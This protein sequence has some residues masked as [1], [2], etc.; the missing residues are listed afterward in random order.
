MAKK[1]KLKPRRL[2]GKPLGRPPY[3]VEARRIIS[4]RC[5][6]KLLDKIDARAG[7]T[8]LQRSDIIKH[9]LQLGLNSKDETSDVFA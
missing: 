3:A 5:P 8:G 2:S 6:V 9:L 7:K 1:R 4:F